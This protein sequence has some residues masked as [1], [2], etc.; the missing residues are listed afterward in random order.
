M[1]NTG[2]RDIMAQAVYLAQLQAAKGNCKC[3][4]CAILRK[5]TDNMT[6]D[7]LG[8]NPGGATSAAQALER[9]Q[10]A[11]LNPQETIDLGGD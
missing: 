9:A 11:N 8:A 6:A 7:F 5:A 3:N 1:Q 2:Q 10:A 4:V